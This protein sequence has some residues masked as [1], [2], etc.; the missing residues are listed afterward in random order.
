MGQPTT[1]F[2]NTAP[3]AS[4]HLAVTP[5]DSSANNF[6]FATTGLYVGVAGSITVVGAD[7]AATLFPNVPVGWHPIRCIRVNST[8]TAQTA[9]QIVAVWG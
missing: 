4:Y 5:S 7:G 8:G 9:G 6:T 1:Y 3:A 2:A